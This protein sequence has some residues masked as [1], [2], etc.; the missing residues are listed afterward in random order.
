MTLEYL[1]EAVEYAATQDDVLTTIHLTSE[2]VRVTYERD[3]YRRGRI[4]A[5]VE[6][7]LAQFNFVLDRMREDI[8]S[9]RS[10]YTARR[11]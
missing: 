6:V 1:K 5:W 8:E 4:F 3:S 10:V 2:G 7:E 9:M 11:G